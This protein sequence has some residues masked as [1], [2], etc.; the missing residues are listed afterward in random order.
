MITVAFELVGMLS[1]CLHMENSCFRMLPNPTPYHWDKKFFSLRKL[2]QEY[3]K[4]IEDE[5]YA[6]QTPHV[7]NLI[8]LAEQVVGELRPGPQDFSIPLLD[9]LHGAILKCDDF[10]TNHTSRELFTMVLREHFQE[11]LRM[12]NEDPIEATA[13]TNGTGDTNDESQVPL[14]SRSPTDTAAS[15]PPA[16]PGGTPR[17]GSDKR[18]PPRFDDLNSASPEEKQAKFINIYFEVVLPRVK[19]Q[20]VGAFERR[21]TTHY[22]PSHHGRDPSVGSAYS[23]G[24]SPE[25][26]QESRPGLLETQSPGSSHMLQPGLHIK[27][28][29]YELNQVNRNRNSEGSV[30]HGFHKALRGIS[31]GD[32]VGHANDIW[33]TLVFR[34]LCWLLLHDFHKKD[35]QISKSELL[36]SRLPVYIA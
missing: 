20:A 24:F 36:G 3:K 14:P 18:S 31:T 29:E 5:D 1:K 17:V 30:Q 8:Q 12:V 4:K 15:P 28:E 9:A 16:V 21:K 23:T 32:L 27:I 7:Q 10:L 13:G 34:M 35:V 2:L 22:A 6:E 33:C 11:I 26:S 25:P 19:L